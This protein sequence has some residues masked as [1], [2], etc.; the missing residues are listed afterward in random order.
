VFLSDTT[1]RKKL[2]SPL[3]IGKIFFLAFTSVSM[4]MANYP[5]PDIN[6]EEVIKEFGNPGTIRD[7][8]RN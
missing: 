7:N 3:I 8:L 2:L 4:K 1:K 6:I 5:I